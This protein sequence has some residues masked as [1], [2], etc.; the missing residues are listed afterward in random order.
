MSGT[1]NSTIGGVFGGGGL[2]GIGYALGVLDG[3]KPRG[4][5]L[6]ESPI[7]GTS[8]GAWAAAATALDVPFE[9][10]ADMQVPSFPNPKPG[11]LASIA[12]EMF[13]DA[14]DP[15][16]HVMAC[17]LPRLKRTILDGGKYPLSELVAASS[18]VPA[19]LSPHKIDGVKY[20]DGGVRSGTSVDYGPVVQQLILIA[21]LAG[22]MW[23]PFA[24]LVDKGLHNEAHRWKERTG[25]KVLMF[26][27]HN[28]AAEIA[29]NPKH[30]FDKARAIE[31]YHLGR[32]E[33]SSYDLTFS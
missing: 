33:A 4:I 11:L 21:P 22:A 9:T 6:S 17:A 27:P 30:L 19:L 1:P 3:L 12:K 25:G 29:R 14:T 16:I 31:A 23:G 2:F 26:T 15:L 7:L 24:R 8:A 32:D 28:H 18:A 5:D 20:V 13:G 10:L